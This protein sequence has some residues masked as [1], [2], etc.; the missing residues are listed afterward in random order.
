MGGLTLE[1]ID[2]TFGALVTDVDLSRLDD[3]NWFAIESAFLEYALLVFP[4]QHL[5]EAAQIAFARRFGDIEMLGE[6]EL[7][8]LTN[9]RQDGS[10]RP[11]GDP[12]MEILRGTEVWHVDSTYM[13]LAAKGAVFSAHTVPS[14][15]GG[16]EWADTR[17][18]YAALDDET[19]ARV[20][21]LSA[22]HSL[23]YSQGRIG[24]PPEGGF[25]GYG[26]HDDP[27]PL[28]P[29][30]KIH[31]V[32]GRPSLMIGRHAYGIPGLEP[33]ESE[34]LLDDL[35]ENACKPPRVYEH[36]WAPG[37]VVVWDNRCLL[38]RARPFDHRELR[39]MK[40]TRIAGDPASELGSA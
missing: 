36:H 30:V 22:Y 26:F 39:L 18:A 37:D 32:T 34:H 3:E 11:D 16:T 4:A 21:E 7:V 27:A 35:V 2:A 38:H 13:P 5:S 8:Y 9:Q 15:G 17:A 19:R 20:D 10:L 14:T 31:P 33:E 29:L 6:R 1:P 24:D 28:R 25:R 23:Y 12:V 40:H